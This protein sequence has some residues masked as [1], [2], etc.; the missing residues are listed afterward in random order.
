[1]WYVRVLVGVG[2]GDP[3]FEVLDETHVP[4]KPN[5]HRNERERVV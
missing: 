5:T 2:G 4:D 3:L 1:M